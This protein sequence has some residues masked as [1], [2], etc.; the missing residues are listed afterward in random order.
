MCVSP[1]TA[2]IS[3]RV[4]TRR[5][6]DGAVRAGAS[7]PMQPP[8]PSH[9]SILGLTRHDFSPELLKKQYRAL[10]LRWHP[11]RNHGNEAAAAEKFKELQEAFGVLSDPQ[12]RAAYDRDLILQRRYATATARTARAAKER[13]EPGSR[14]PPPAAA[15]EPPPPSP[16]SH[17][18]HSS[19]AAPTPASP[20][21]PPP[22]PPPPVADEA[23]PPATA[24]AE[25]SARRHER[26]GEG[27][28]QS[29][30]EAQ[31]TTSRGRRSRERH[32]E[33]E[34]VAL[35]PGEDWPG[36]AA[37][38]ALSER[39]AREEEQ[40]DERA[41]IAD[42]L[43]A[44]RREAEE[45]AEALRLVENAMRQEREEFEEAL[46]AVSLAESGVAVPAD[47]LS[48]QPVRAPVGRVPPGFPANLLESILGERPGSGMGGTS[49]IA[50]LAA[51]SAEQQLAALMELG[52]H[53]EMAAPYCD[54][55]SPI[56]DIVEQLS[57]D[58]DMADLSTGMHGD[59]EDELYRDTTPTSSR[60]TGR[61]PSGFMS[62]RRMMSRRRFARPPEP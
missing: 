29:T 30:S 33:R 51:S 58:L 6:A 46:H 4:I 43:E 61:R 62:M 34:E 49:G 28:P 25:P 52:F 39:T 22:P 27:A 11:D 5:A 44:E 41:A 14:A 3:V 26:V 18:Q 17:R 2:K 54:G 40:R 32:E 53:A 55:V 50:S 21:P 35:D 23:A 12:A 9:Y 15:A 8:P 56:E 37:A 45:I 57:M 10:A 16:R 24:R 20:A 48:Q 13:D 1:V 7:Q 36:L 31:S 60:S 59:M 47:T 42:V 38:L 19:A